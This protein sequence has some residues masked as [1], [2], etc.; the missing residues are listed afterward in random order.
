MKKVRL[1]SKKFDSDQKKFYSDQKKFYSD[2]KKFYSIRK[3]FYSDQNS[4]RKRK[5]MCFAI[6]QENI[7]LGETNT[8]ELE[9][10]NTI[11]QT[12]PNWPRKLSVAWWLPPGEKVGMVACFQLHQ[13]CVLGDF[14]RE[15]HSRKNLVGMEVAVPKP[16]SSSFYSSSW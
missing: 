7:N 8:D 14:M 15:I 9:Q 4:S 12:L 6:S 3:K 1:R 11:L 2:R 16:S 10:R 5:K 13:K